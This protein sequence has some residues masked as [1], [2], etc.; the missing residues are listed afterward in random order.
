VHRRREIWYTCQV[1]NS[2]SP[3]VALLAC[4]HISHH[5]L[6]FVSLRFDMATM[7]QGAMFCMVGSTLD[8][9]SGSLGVNPSHASQLACGLRLVESFTVLRLAQT[10]QKGSPTLPRPCCAIDGDT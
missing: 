10:L 3:C 7:L 4:M 8:S 9:R 1:P 6:K 5:I 2:R